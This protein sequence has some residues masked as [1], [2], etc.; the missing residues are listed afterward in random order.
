MV[1]YSIY[2]KGGTMIDYIFYLSVDGLIY[3]SKLTGLTY[4]EVNFWLFFIIWPSITII[5][6]ILLLKS[7]GQS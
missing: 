3:L 1:L 7:R 6:F 5:Q 4:Q 2:F